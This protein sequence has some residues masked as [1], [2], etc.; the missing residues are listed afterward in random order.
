MQLFIPTLFRYSRLKRLIRKID[1]AENLRR[2]LSE[3]YGSDFKEDW[4]GRWYTVL[5]PLVRNMQT[6]DGVPFEYTE[7]GVTNRAY[8]ERWCM[9]RMFAASQFIKNKELLDIMTYSIDRL[10]DSEN[11]LF[12]L[13]PVLFDSLIKTAKRFFISAAVLAVAAVAVLL[14]I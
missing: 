1:S 7:D 12:V 5:N 4:A 2:N 13:K 8:I 9:D 6:T 11:Y 14:I 10:D 3:L